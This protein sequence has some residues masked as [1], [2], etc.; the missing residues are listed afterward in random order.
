MI[1]QPPSLPARLLRFGFRQ[2]YT[3]FAWLYDT[4]AD[5]V[6]LGEWQAWGRTVMQFI[7]TNASDEGQEP[8]SL[9]LLELAHGPGH[10]HLTLCQAG[11][12]AVGIDL[13]AQMSALAS[14]RLQR[15]GLTN[16]LAR[17]SVFEL[18]FPSATFDAVVS[19]FPTEFIF[20]PQMLDEAAR[21]LKGA[22]RLIV[23]PGAPLHST[24]ADE[25]AIQLAYRITRQNPPA[26]LPIQ[27][28]FEQSGLAFGERR[29]STRH[30]EVVI[31]LGDK[32]PA[33]TSTAE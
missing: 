27:R 15:A 19:T 12:H 16:T 17:A 10:L 26:P 5:V 1:L 9:R 3:R 13:S 8:S 20:A 18:P 22:G 23:V 2:L 4:V 31:W 14:R 7:H 32:R 25:R 33:D 11:Y 28:L 21:V 6:S 30:A 29:V 24:Q